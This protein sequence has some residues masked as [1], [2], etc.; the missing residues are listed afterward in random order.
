M[1]HVLLHV[2]SKSQGPLSIDQIRD[3]WPE[4]VY[5]PSDGYVWSLAGGLIE[6]GLVAYGEKPFTYSIV[7]AA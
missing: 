1:H 4:L 5:K 6:K 3:R 7:R 2:L